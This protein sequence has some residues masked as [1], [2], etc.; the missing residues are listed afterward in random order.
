MEGVGL[1]R[2]RRNGHCQC[3]Y[4]HAT[5]QVQGQVRMKLLRQGLDQQ[6]QAAQELQNNTD[7]IIVMSDFP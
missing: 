4:R 6:E 5:K 7:E 1:N 3:H 2:P